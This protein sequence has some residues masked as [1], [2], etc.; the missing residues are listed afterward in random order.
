MTSVWWR[1]S[2]IQTGYEK[3]VL[4]GTPVSDGTSSYLSL[5]FWCMIPWRGE[6]RERRR[7]NSF[8]D[9]VSVKKGFTFIS[10]HGYVL[11]GIRFATICFNS[12]TFV[13]SLRRNLPTAT[14]N[15]LMSRHSRMSKPSPLSAWHR[16]RFSWW[17]DY[18]LLTVPY[19]SF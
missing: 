16:T 6:V 10:T 19:N 5:L 14:K 9:P 2:N 12:D 13:C 15:I 8:A 18:H 3:T 7:M 11:H 4:V 17:H 1:L